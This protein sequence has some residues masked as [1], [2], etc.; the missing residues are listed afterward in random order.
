MFGD[1]DGVV[2][3][4]QAISAAVLASAVEKIGSENI[5]RSEL[6]AGATLAEVFARHATL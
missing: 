2:V 4:P 5:T 1:L 3:I 6:Q